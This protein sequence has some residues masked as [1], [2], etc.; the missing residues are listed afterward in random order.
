[1]LLAS[2]QAGDI[3][4]VVWVSMIA[5]VLVSATFSFVVLGL[6]RSAEAARGGRGTA[7]IA[8]GALSV[9]AFAM[10]AA[11]VIFGVQVMLS[12]G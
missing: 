11:I 3:F 6:G 9:V 12:K 2:V 10:F 1:V 5:G 7:A 4:H 8:Y